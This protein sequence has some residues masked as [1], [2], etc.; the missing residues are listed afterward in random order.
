MVDYPISPI[1][2]ASSDAGS[3]YFSDNDDPSSSVN[4]SHIYKV[5]MTARARE[6]RMRRMKDMTEEKKEG[7][8]VISPGGNHNVSSPKYTERSLSASRRRSNSNSKKAA[9]LQRAVSPTSKESS[10][11]ATPKR[12]NVSGNNKNVYVHEIPSATPSTPNS[13][14]PT[15]AFP[16]SRSAFPS[17]TPLTSPTG[18]FVTPGN[19]SDVTE[20]ELKVAEEVFS[21]ATTPSIMQREEIFHHKAAANIVRLLTPDRMIKGNFAASGG[22]IEGCAIAINEHSP[23][24]VTASPGLGDPTI[25]SFGNWNEIDKYGFKKVP[26]KSEVPE[27]EDEVVHKVL[28][29]RMISPNQQLADLLSQV[30]RDLKSTPEISRAYAT[31]RKNACGA[32]KVLSAK[33]ENRLKLCWTAGVLDAVSSV[34]NDVKTTTLDELSSNA[35]TEGRNRMVSVLLNLAANKKNRMLICN[36]E[37]VLDSINACI[38]GDDG[39]SRHGCCMVLLQLAKTSQTRPLIIRCPGLLDNLA[40]VIE[41]PKVLPPPPSPLGTPSLRKG[42][43]NPYLKIFESTM[44]PTQRDIKSDPSRSFA[45][46]NDTTISPE[47]TLT[48]SEDESTNRVALSPNDTTMSPEESIYSHEDL[49]T[50][51]EGDSSYNS[52]SSSSGA[53]THGSHTTDHTEEHTE[54]HTE[55]SGSEEGGENGVEES[56]GSDEASHGLAKCIVIQSMSEMEIC[57]KTTSDEKQEENDYDADPNR[58]LH[59]ARL[60][61]FGCLLCLVK[62]KENAVSNLYLSCMLPLVLFRFENASDICASM[63]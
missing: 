52:S 39:E 29:T 17:S 2:P 37:G 48:D 55:S 33:E 63:P 20:E 61:I 13:S 1:S 31:R 24:D 14:F 21:D 12:N 57:F 58:F 53:E 42:Y 28:T 27:D 32:L 56:V 46:P 16:P 11:K 22:V 30:K 19:D 36:T 6:R 9:A 47:E 23:T 10:T 51:T 50:D 35:N 34:L 15:T 44:S 45:S 18:G 40:K 60:N 26:N 5:A 3:S 8:T 59:S 54:H 43:E 62:S 41:V 38:A 25:T 4:K 49:D 7:R